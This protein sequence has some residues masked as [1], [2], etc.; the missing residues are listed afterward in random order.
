MSFMSVEDKMT[1][2]LYCKTGYG[3]EVLPLRLCSSTD[4]DC[5][6]GVEGWVGRRW[7]PFRPWLREI[8]SSRCRFEA[9]S[10][11]VQG[12]EDNGQVF[13]LMDLPL[14]LREQIYLQA[15]G[16]TV[17]SRIDVYTLGC[18][19]SSPE[20]RDGNSD[21]TQ[22]IPLATR[23]IHL[24]DRKHW[25]HPVLHKIKWVAES[26]QD[27]TWLPAPNYNLFA[28][29]KQVHSEVLRVFSNLT[30]KRFRG[31]SMYADWKTS[32]A[33]TTW[34]SGV[35]KNPFN[36]PTG[37]YGPTDFRNPWT[38]QLSF[39]S[40]SQIQLCYTNSEFLHFSHSS[41]VEDYTEGEPTIT[42][43]ELSYLPSLRHLDF[44]FL[45]PTEDNTADGIN[46]RFHWCQNELVDFFF[47]DA[48]EYLRKFRGVAFTMSGC[49]KRSTRKKWQNVLQEMKRGIVHDFT[50]ERKEILSK[51]T[52]SCNCSKPCNPFSKNFNG[53]AVKVWHENNFP[54]EYSEDTDSG[55]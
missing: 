47:I 46:L 30:F 38:I 7:A 16:C 21:V 26:T 6:G 28:T 35:H 9:C 37:P 17:E 13:R 29:S 44:H 8:F 48:L 18:L 32:C 5:D 22:D 31:H 51:G 49:V 15:L 53:V 1:V 36:E 40:L 3:S 14:E 4:T 50:E 45:P 12:W 23:V 43:K 10:L 55:Q 20:K 25:S 39:E 33:S 42:V 2:V 19:K 52:E 41:V 34:I 54:S 24:S 11:L 27:K